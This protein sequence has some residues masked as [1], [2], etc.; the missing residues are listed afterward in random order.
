VQNFTGGPEPLLRADQLP[1]GGDTYNLYG[2]KYDAA[3]EVASD[4]SFAR[5]A[6]RRSGAYAGRG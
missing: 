6:A 2:V 3:G 1:V 4:L 5:R